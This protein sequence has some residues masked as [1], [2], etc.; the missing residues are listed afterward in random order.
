MAGAAVAGAVSDA[1][2]DDD[3]GDDGDTE[4]RYRQWVTTDRCTLV[5]RIESH[6]SALML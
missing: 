4:V 5:E 1:S 2:H 6:E 3:N